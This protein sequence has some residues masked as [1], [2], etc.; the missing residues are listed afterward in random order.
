MN[1]EYQKVVV[2]YANGFGD[3]IMSLPTLRA[4]ASIFGERMTLVCRENDGDI[5][6]GS[7]G[8]PLVF[9]KFVFGHGR[10]TF[11]PEPV[12]EAI[13]Q[14]DLLICLSPWNPG[15]DIQTLF[16]HWEAHTIGFFDGFGSRV[17]FT[18]KKH[19]ALRT[20]NFASHLDS[21]L[22][23]EDFNQPPLLKRSVRQT[24]DRVIKILPNNA[25]ILCVHPETAA[26]KMWSKDKF[27]E[28]IDR[29]LEKHEDYVVA[30]VPS[31][32]MGF[33]S[34]PYKDRIFSCTLPLAIVYALISKC[35]LFLGIDSCMMHA[36]DF[37]R[38][39]TVGL[40]GPTD[41]NEFGCLITNYRHVT[42][43][44]MDQIEVDQVLGALESLCEAEV[45]LV[46]T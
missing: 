1:H 10:H 22:R 43:K 32:S 13:P 21:S 44:T 42:G 38:V 35:H 34:G 15:D 36:A 4:L 28:V 2:L 18:S 37:F 6:F 26:E 30:T 20:F 14:C 11:D 45:P 25:K 19:A 23:F 29:F 46:S 31:K 33:D 41:P 16:D 8:V 7:L 40:F 39:P 12:L 17:S 24:A 9:T 3:A 27:Q 5:L